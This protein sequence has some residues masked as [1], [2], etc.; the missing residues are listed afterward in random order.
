MDDLFNQNEEPA[1]HTAKRN[2]FRTAGGREATHGPE[3]PNKR[4]VPAT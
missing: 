4:F 3:R 1:S 2:T